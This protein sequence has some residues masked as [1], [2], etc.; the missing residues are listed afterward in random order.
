MKRTPFYHEFVAAGAIFQETQGWQVPAR[1]S[2]SRE[3]HLAVRQ[4]AGI[5][6]WSSTGEIEIK[7]CDALTVIQ[8]IIVNDASRMS[9]GRVLYSTLCQPDGSILSDVT[10]YRLGECHYWIMTAWGSNRNNQF[11]E[12]EW[13]SEHSHGLN[14]S[15]TDVSSGV[16]L[17]SVQGPSSRDIVA[18]LT[19]AD[20]GQLPYMHAVQAPL[21]DAPRGLISRTGYTGEL[22][23]ELVVPTEHSYELWEALS[24]SGRPYDI[25][26]VGQEA[27]FSLRI[28]KSYIMRLDFS[29]HVTP[30]EA[31]LGWTVKFGKVDFVGKETLWKQRQEGLSRRLVTLIMLDEILPAGG[32][33]ICQD[34]RVVGQVTSSAHGYSVGCPIALGL[35]ETAAGNP[36]TDLTVNVDGKAHPAKVVAHSPYDPKGIRIRA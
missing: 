34:A 4:R 23:Y 29:D 16:A 19:P 5:L 9:V 35:V 26:L 2:S 13:I 27:A 20:L 18:R 22:G 33:L 25:A 14:V 3:E 10:V 12:F 7:G 1:F 32:S 6:D 31:G 24:D 28:E 17:I 15:I 8:R 21:A 30:L 11:P 36:G